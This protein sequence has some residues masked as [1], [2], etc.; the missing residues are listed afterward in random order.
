MVRARAHLL[1]GVALVADGGVA[2]ARAPLL[3]L[4]RLG[5]QQQRC[6][7]P[8]NIARAQLRRPQRQQVLLPLLVVVMGVLPGL[9]G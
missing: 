2:P 6:G 8:V 3:M 4:A 7:P 9:V 5:A 1:A